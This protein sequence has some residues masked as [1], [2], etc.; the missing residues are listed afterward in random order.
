[1]VQ[2]KYWIEGGE[3]N[4]VHM[5][6][7]SNTVMDQIMNRFKAVKRP[8]IVLIVPHFRTKVSIVVGRSHEIVQSFLS[9][10]SSSINY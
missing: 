5:P 4:V 8:C 9:V 7:T 3:D 1:M 10:G 6:K 2:P